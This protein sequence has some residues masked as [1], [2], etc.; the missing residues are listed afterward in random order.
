LAVITTHGEFTIYR[1]IT[2]VSVVA[3]NKPPFSLGYKHSQFKPEARSCFPG[4]K[5][6]F[7]P[8]VADANFCIR[9]EVEVSLN[10]RDQV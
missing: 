6:K 9:T 1:P 2:L 4:E 10:S 8:C 5:R 3:A 7:L